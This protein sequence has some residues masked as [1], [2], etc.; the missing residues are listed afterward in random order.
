M[1]ENGYK[2]KLLLKTKSLNVY[3]SSG[4]DQLMKQKK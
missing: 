1:L 3:D 2:Y 4:F